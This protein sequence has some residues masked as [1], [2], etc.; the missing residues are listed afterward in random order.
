MDD[1]GELH[2][3]VKVVVVGLIF[4]ACVALGMWFAT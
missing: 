4:V 1:D 2:F 3:A